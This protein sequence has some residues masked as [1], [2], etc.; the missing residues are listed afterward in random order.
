MLSDKMFDM[1]SESI[2]RDKSYRFALEA[3]DA[4]QHLVSEKK[5]F[6]LSKQFLRSATSIGANVREARGA[7]SRAD[8]INKLSIAHKEAFETDYWLCL[9]RD[10]K[11][12]SDDK[13][14]HLLDLNTELIKILTSSLLTSK[15][16]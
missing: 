6:I 4:Y 5:E 7:Q 10:S 14:E 8:F 1:T 9:L 16:Q 11:I 3:I 13:A 15:H 2:L 12:L